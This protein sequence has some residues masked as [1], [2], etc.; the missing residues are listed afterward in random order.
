MHAYSSPLIIN[1]VAKD[2]DV[3]PSQQQSGISLSN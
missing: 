1:A 2:L 3:Q